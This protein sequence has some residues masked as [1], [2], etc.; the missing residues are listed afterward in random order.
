MQNNSHVKRHSKSFCNLNHFTQVLEI[1]HPEDLV[2]IPTTSPLGKL[3]ISSQLTSQKVCQ[4]IQNSAPNHGL[5]MDSLAQKQDVTPL[6]TRTILSNLINQKKPCSEWLQ[7]YWCSWW[8]S[9]FIPHF[10]SIQYIIDKVLLNH[11]RTRL[12]SLNKFLHESL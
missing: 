7:L 4:K 2:V 3:W 12:F 11:V 5:L 6:I 9:H 8:P 1:Q 10:H